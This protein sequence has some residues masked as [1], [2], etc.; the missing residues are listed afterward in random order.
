MP[1]IARG[2]TLIELMITVA[3][4]GILASV[5]LP[6][7]TEYVRRGKITEATSTLADLRFQMERYYQDN[8]RYTVAAGSSVC[9]VPAPA[10]PAVKYFTYACAADGGD[11][12][13]EWTATGQVSENM[14]GF[15]FSIDE[16]NNKVTNAFPDASGL[17]AQCWMS[18]KGDLC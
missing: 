6:A 7:Y 18:K 16:A 3:I 4:I 5:A 14:A 13:Y 10:P 9:G 15:S 1:S 17:P 11:Q 2:F 8:R 12:T